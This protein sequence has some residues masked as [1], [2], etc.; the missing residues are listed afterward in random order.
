MRIVPLVHIH[1][2]GWAMPDIDRGFQRTGMSCVLLLATAA[3]STTERVTPNVVR[4]SSGVTIVESHAPLWNAA[5]TWAVSAEPQLRIEPRADDDSVR[6]FTRITGLTRLSSGLIVALEAAA[7]ELRWFD[8]IGRHLRTSRLRGQGPRELRFAS[9]L[10][11]LPGDT[12]LVDGN[13]RPNKSLVFSSTGEFVREDVMDEQRLR[14]SGRWGECASLVL[15]DRSRLLCQELPGATPLP[16]DPGPGYLREFLQFVRVSW[17][18]TEVDTLGRYGGIEQ[19]GLDLGGKWTDFQVHPFYSRSHVAAGGDPL[20]IAI[21]VNPAYSI[22]LWTSRD[23]LDRIVR[24]TG[25]LRKPTDRERAGAVDLMREW[26][27]QHTDP[28][29]MDRVLAGVPVPDSLPAA[30]GLVFSSGGELLVAREGLLPG[31]EQTLYDVFDRDG[32]FLG[33]LRFPPSFTIREVGIDYVLGV[34]LAADDVPV[35]ELYSLRRPDA[36]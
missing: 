6:Q 24:R 13:N 27:R 22:E 3:C 30:W 20:R 8:P 21:A 35:I 34:R 26:N 28:A 15:P 4:D 16:P 19:V 23:G 12:L 1:E 2:G 25:P 17:D 18:V 9:A 29:M 5:T 11:R 10:N 14:S 32:R 7:L 33:E 36:R 31:Q